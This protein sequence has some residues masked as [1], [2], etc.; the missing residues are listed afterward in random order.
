MHAACLESHVLVHISVQTLKKPKKIFFGPSVA[1]LPE[2]KHLPNGASPSWQ[3]KT[4]EFPSKTPPRASPVCVLPACAR[5]PQLDVAAGRTP[6]APC[7]PPCALHAHRLRVL[8]ARRA[9]GFAA[10]SL[11]DSRTGSGTARILSTGH[12]PMGCER[13]PKVLGQLWVLVL[14]DSHPAGIAA[15]C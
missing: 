8:H 11:R 2:L 15:P 6:A 1:F 3:A 7:K 14:L 9:Q 10:G 12:V 4:R 13:T 5:A